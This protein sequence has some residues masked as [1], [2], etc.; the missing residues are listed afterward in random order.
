[1]HGLRKPKRFYWLVPH[2]EAS[3]NYC[4]VSSS[5]R[6][7]QVINFLG[8]VKAK[9]IK[10]ICIKKQP[11]QSTHLC[12]LTW[13]IQDTDQ[14]FHSHT[15]FSNMDTIWMMKHI[16]TVFRLLNRSVFGRFG[17]TILH[18]WCIYSVLLAEL[19]FEQLFLSQKRWLPFLWTQW[20]T[21]VLESHYITL[22]YLP[23]NRKFWFWIY[24]TKVF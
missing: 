19:N 5:F 13:V 16:N 22:W 4:L 23:L 14:I 9:K 2:L 7:K 1:M 10:L 15:W 17:R 21:L 18:I 20:W 3:S 12:Q 24:R 8:M 6:S 11:W